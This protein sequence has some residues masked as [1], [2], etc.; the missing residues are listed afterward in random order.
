M[1]SC[2]SSERSLSLNKEKRLKQYWSEF[3]DNELDDAQ[4]NQY[5]NRV[6]SFLELLVRI[7]KRNQK[8]TTCKPT[9]II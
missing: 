9:K 6:K 3:Y 8:E 7:E 1:A 5:S 4:L 2:S